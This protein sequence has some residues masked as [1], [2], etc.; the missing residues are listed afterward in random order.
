MVRER[1]EITTSADAGEKNKTPRKKIGCLKYSKGIIWKHSLVISHVYVGYKILEPWQD[2]GFGLTHSG[3]WNRESAYPQQHKDFVFVNMGSVSRA[4]GHFG[5]QQR[6]VIFLTVFL[7]GFHSPC[8]N[9]S[10]SSC[11][12]AQPGW[13]KTSSDRS[14]TAVFLPTGC[15][16]DQRW[17]DGTEW[18]SQWSLFSG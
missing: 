12:S 18:A 4:L 13:F 3:Q 7:A 16:R 14:T 17:T 15:S 10:C 9:S 11:T 6:L 2:D 5:P 8:W 1:I